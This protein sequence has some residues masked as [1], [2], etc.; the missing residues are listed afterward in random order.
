MA[1]FLDGHRV[2]AN[3]FFLD[4]FF[5]GDH[6]GFLDSDL[7]GTDLKLQP[8]VAGS[9]PTLPGQISGQALDPADLRPIGQPCYQL[10]YSRLDSQGQPP[11]FGSYI[12]GDENGCH[13]RRI[14]V[15]DIFI[16]RDLS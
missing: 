13:D 1:D 7:L 11:D 9:Q 15:Y 12:S 4:D 6:L 10:F 5:S 16:K 2:L 8:I 3:L 14:G